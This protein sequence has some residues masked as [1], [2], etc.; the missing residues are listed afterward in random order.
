MLAAVF[1]QQTLAR[2]SRG[3]EKQNGTEQRTFAPLR[4]RCHPK[5]HRWNRKRRRFQRGEGDTRTAYCELSEP[6]LR[7]QDARDNH[8]PTLKEAVGSSQLMEAAAEASRIAVTFCADLRHQEEED[9]K[10]EEEDQ[11]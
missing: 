10:D 5:E 6:R 9:E 4:V 3:H 8:N 7:L 1:S 11:E 2:G